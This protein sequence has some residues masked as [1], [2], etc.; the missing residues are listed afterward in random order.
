MEPV[1]AYLYIYLWKIHR[2]AGESGYLHKRIADKTAN[3]AIYESTMLKEMQ[4]LHLIGLNDPKPV[5]L[6]KNEVSRGALLKDIVYMSPTFIMLARGHYLWTEPLF[7][8]IQWLLAAVVGGLI[9]L[10]ISA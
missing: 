6:P 10:V 7:G 9:A 4:E 5:E 1:P 3:E 8:C 2:H